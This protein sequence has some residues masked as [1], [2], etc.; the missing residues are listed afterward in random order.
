MT[1]RV[2]TQSAR[3]AAAEVAE[4]RARSRRGRGSASGRPGRSTRRGCGSSRRG[5]CR[6][7][8]RPCREAT[9]EALPPDEPPAESSGSQGFRV[10]PKRAFSVT[11]R[12]AELRRVRLADDDRARLAQAAHVRAVV[13]GHPVAECRA[14]LGGRHALGGGEQVLD[15]DRDS[16]QRPW[17]AGAHAV[18]LGQRALSA[19]RDERVQR[20]VRAARSPAATA[21]T[22]SR[23]EISPA[24]TSAACSTAVERRTSRYVATAQPYR[25]GCSVERHVHRLRQ[26]LLE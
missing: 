13:V 12:S 26:R 25:G 22:S 8:A 6:R 11:G 7:R 1:V 3:H 16:A 10:A 5:R 18:G 4:V 14:S 24:R 2:R 17:V 19:E 21:S 15:A 9:A 20:R 23:A